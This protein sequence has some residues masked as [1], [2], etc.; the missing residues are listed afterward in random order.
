MEGRLDQDDLLGE[1]DAVSQGDRAS[2]G[3]Y[4]GGL[5]HGIAEL[6]P[7]IGDPTL[8]KANARMLFGELG[9]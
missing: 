7:H 2:G 4:R 6:S 1:I 8:N 3:R 5:L 9:P